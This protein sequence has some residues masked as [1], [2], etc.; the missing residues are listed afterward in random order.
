MYARHLEPHLKAA[1][2]DTP[3]V[4]LLGARQVGKTTL[5]RPLAQVHEGGGPVPRYITLDELTPLAAAQADPEG[6]LA[7]ME[8]PVILDEVQRAPQL[9]QAI[10]A[11]VDR[12]RTPGRFLLTGSA[13]PMLLP[14]V[15]ES[16]AGRVETLTLWPL[17]QSEIEQAPGRFI[18][19]LFGE[20]LPDLP[21]E[22]PDAPSVWERMAR[23]GFPEAVSRADPDRRD[24]WFASYLTTL[25]Q[26]DIRDL[27]GVE[28]SG[29]LLRLVQMMAYRSGS[30]VNYSELSRTVG[31]P[32]STLRRYAGLLEATFLYREVPA[33]T[34]NLGKR[35]T[36]AP[37]GFI[38]D[39][40]LMASLCG[41]D[42]SNAQGPMR[43][44]L[45][46]TFVALELMKAASWSAKSPILH[47][48]RTAT[49]QE[50]DFVLE[51]RDGLRVGI[52]V[53]AAR[54]CSR[55]DFSGLLTFRDTAP[56]RFHRG[57]VLY[58]G[59]HVLPF[60]DHMWAVPMRALWGW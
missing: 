47:H 24:R 1:L 21:P 50:V 35:L 18:D 6:F 48:F 2:A 42:P 29:A 26:R 33:W 17:A 51:R 19:V 34:A 30:L 52:E 41:M 10:K 13:D 60:G 59:E 53:K 14:E 11:L 8:G 37:K 32:L 3:V 38:T 40:G 44:A 54:S 16:L 56:E 58:N 27:A 25:L 12:D 55:S 46:E 15:S 39:T 49:G 22:P 57:I 36:K 43:G 9:F 5:V 23:G 4:L 7:A 20:R 31:I 45:L 28:A